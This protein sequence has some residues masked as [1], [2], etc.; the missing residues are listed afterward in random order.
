MGSICLYAQ[1]APNKSVDLPTF[2]ITGK[3][4][5]EFP[6]AEKLSSPPIT[7]VTEDF[8]K[9]SYDPEFL[10]ATVSSNPFGHKAIIQD[11]SVLHRNKLMGRAGSVTLP[12][13]MYSTLFNY[14]DIGASFRI[15]S[16][17]SLPYVKNGQVFSISPEI[18]LS[19]KVLRSGS[20]IDENQ[21]NV[22]SRFSYTSYRFYAVDQA[23]ARKINKFALGASLENSTSDFWK[24]KGSAELRSISLGDEKVKENRT[25]FSGSAGFA[26]KT[27]EFTP[28]AQL[29][30]NSTGDSLAVSRS[31]TLLQASAPLK[32]TISDVLSAYGALHLTLMD[33]IK[34]VNPNFGVFFKLNSFI[35]LSASFS[36]GYQVYDFDNILNENRFASLTHRSLFIYPVDSKLDLSLTFESA[37]VYDLTFGFS[38]YKSDRYPYYNSGTNG[39]FYLASGSVTVFNMRAELRVHPATYGYFVSSV[40]LNAIKDSIGN[41]IPNSAPFAAYAIYGYNLQEGVTL[42]AGGK[43]LSG[44]Y[45]DIANNDKLPMTISLFT[46]FGYSFSREFL[47]T[48]K[49]DNLLNR[50]NLILKG[51]QDR[52]LTLELGVEFQW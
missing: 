27:I 37:K 9:P 8:L 6:P 34:T 47:L 16:E 1:E 39:A 32:I 48:A 35:S 46:E 15:G 2:V 23:P 28:T 41:Y 19:Y 30:F 21:F 24:Y 43:F 11:S 10:V 12:G 20:W 40:Q 44:R 26:G 7:V 13:L 5:I 17:Y 3:E 45:N 49:I 50:K 18:D 38:S 51:Y 33:S 42:K 14:N 31:V 36:P 29:S 4:T 52:P 25:I 22:F